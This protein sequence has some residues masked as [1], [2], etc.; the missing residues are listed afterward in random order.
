MS[1]YKPVPQRLRVL[2][3]EDNL[4]DAEL[5]KSLLEEEWPDCVI[6][7]VQTRDAF[8]ASL[9]AAQFDLILSDF[10]L[11][12]FDGLSALA[13]ARQRDMSTPFIFISGTIGEDNAVDALRRGAT[14]YVIKDRPARLIPAIHRALAEVSVHQQRRHAEAQLREQ[15]ELLDKARDAIVVSNPERVITYWNQAAAR[16]FGW[17]AAEA[18]GRSAVDLFGAGAIAEIEGARQALTDS[19]EWRGEVRLHNKA[20]EPLIMDSRVTIIRDQAG[21]P[22]SQLIISTDI[23]EQKK[24]EQQFLQSQ[25]IESIGI[26]AGG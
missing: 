23:T 14:D 12:Q 6:D 9:R 4:A 3:V 17:T 18:L 5:I 13:L 26:L 25:R 2:H 15:A 24:L 21:R 7:R 22:R 1:Q 11:P 16:I 8:M 19:D 20:G 10:S